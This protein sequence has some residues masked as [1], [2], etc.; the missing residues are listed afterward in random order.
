METISRLKTRLT[1]PHWGNIHGPKWEGL[2][3]YR[4]RSLR[5]YKCLVR[6]VMV[7]AM[8]R[9][10]KV[11]NSKDVHRLNILR[12]KTFTVIQLNILDWIVEILRNI[13]SWLSWQL[14]GL[15]SRSHALLHGQME[16]HVCCDCSE[17]CWEYQ[18]CIPKQCKLAKT[19]AR[20][21]VS[22]TTYSVCTRFSRQ[23]SIKVSVQFTDR[24]TST[25]WSASR[26][27]D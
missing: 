22:L 11:S 23:I 5:D 18:M 17:W 21:G 12:A 3:G 16:S 8:K 13:F 27:L 7:H 19:N 25:N 6:T 9:T 2:F 10:D 4:Q 14:M 26:I 20:C 15:H 24:K 1:E